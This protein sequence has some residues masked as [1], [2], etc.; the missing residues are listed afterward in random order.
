M[1]RH[2]SIAAFL[3]ATALA[4]PA[5]ALNDAVAGATYL[6]EFNLIV[7]DDMSLTSE[8]E[9]KAFIGGDLLA[10]S[11]GNFGIGSSASGNTQGQA[12]TG[13]HPILF[14]GGN[15]LTG[16][17]SIHVKNGP[18]GPSGNLST[19][20]SSAVIGGN[21]QAIEL[22]D[23][24]RSWTVGGNLLNAGNFPINNMRLGGNVL[25]GNLGGV[26]GGTIEYGASSNR[27]NFNGATAISN[28]ALA[29]TIASEVATKVANVVSDVKA[30]ST[31]LAGMT[32][33]NPSDF[34][35]M[36]SDLTLTAVDGGE[37]FA[38]FNL[39]GNALAGL[40]HI[41][42]SSP[43]DLT[44]VVNITG[45]SGTA[46]N[47]DMT[48]NSGDKLWM[49]QNV[50]W[51]FVDATTLTINDEFHGTLLAPLA[52][53]TIGSQVNG[54]VVANVFHGNAEVHLGAYNGITTFTPPSTPAVPEPATWAMMIGGLGLVGASMRRRTSVAFA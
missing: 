40:Q 53:V 3:A 2:I 29:A 26:S 51:N 9:G 6:K 7:F 25:D 30:L 54:T 37:G 14:V 19:T 44:V 12:T 52:E 4:A 13:G 10:G 18:N 42:F 38:L 8:V 1:V 17:N 16:F 15:N 45:L 39:D 5:Y 24:Q 49:N 28:P 27:I 32:V 35:I 11:S 43:S 33:L 21:S 47:W 20:G 36:G 41:F 50:I 31:E 46:F 22:Q 34:N 48:V 23:G